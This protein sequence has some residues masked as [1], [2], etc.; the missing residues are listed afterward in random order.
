MLL[1]RRKRALEQRVEKLKSEL[2]GAGGQSEEIELLRGEV[3]E[4]AE[5]FRNEK[6]A[7]A[8]VIVEVKQANEQVCLGVSCPLSSWCLLPWLRCVALPTVPVCG[9][10]A[11]VYLVRISS[12][13]CWFVC[14]AVSVT[15]SLSRWSICCPTLRS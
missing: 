12:A 2:D 10:C 6:E 1:H 13:G 9:V 14:C 8:V 3:H 15:Y 11:A 7:R 5:L 4:A